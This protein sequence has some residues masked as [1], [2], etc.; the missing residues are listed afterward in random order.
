MIV[1]GFVVGSPGCKPGSG[2]TSSHKPPWFRSIGG[3][4]NRSFYSQET[5]SASIFAPGLLEIGKAGEHLHPKLENDNPCLYRLCSRVP[6]RCLTAVISLQSCP[7]EYIDDAVAN[8]HET[9][10]MAACCYDYTITRCLA[11]STL[12]LAVF[13]TL[14]QI[15]DSSGAWKIS[16]CP[17]LMAAIF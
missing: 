17:S 3:R 4:S 10:N 2:G 1:V 6:A 8:V 9:P 5:F 16:E 7:H 14:G 11:P 13:H 15:T 12:P